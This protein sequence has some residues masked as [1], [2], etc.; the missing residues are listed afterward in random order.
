MILANIADHDEIQHYT[1]TVSIGVHTFHNIS[2][3]NLFFYD[4]YHEMFSFL[5]DEIEHVSLSA[6]FLCRYNYIFRRD[7]LL[8]FFCSGIHFIYC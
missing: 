1:K 2:L 4:V 3:L 8:D 6:W 5:Y 7:Y